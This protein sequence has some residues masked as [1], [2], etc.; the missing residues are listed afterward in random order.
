M[1]T[2]SPTDVVNTASPEPVPHM[3]MVSASPGSTGDANRASMWANLADSDPQSV[4]SSARPVKPYEHSPC[5][6]GRWN[7][8]FLANAG[9]V[10]SGLRSPDSRY[11]NA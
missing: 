5:R 8:P 11:T 6:I 9:S 10:C 3:L 2:R 1:T 7:P 4:C